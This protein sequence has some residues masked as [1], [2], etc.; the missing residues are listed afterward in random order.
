MNQIRVR[1]DLRLA[2]PVSGGQ[3]RE[4]L[5]AFAMYCATRVTRDLAGIEW[6]LFVIGGL[7]GSADAL[8]RASV[9]TTSVE[10]RSSA[11]DPAHAIWNVMCQVEQPL[12]HAVH[13]RAA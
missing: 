6:E 7:D 5:I 13:S 8:V 3:D 4:D 12:R 10:A 2:P 9:G 1:T 11:S